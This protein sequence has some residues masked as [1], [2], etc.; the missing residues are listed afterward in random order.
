MGFVANF[1]SFSAY[2][3]FENWLRFNKVTERLKVGTFL[4]HSVN[5]IK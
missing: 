4:R 3:D 2:K 1:V 5:N